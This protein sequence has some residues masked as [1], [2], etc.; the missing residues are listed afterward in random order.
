MEAAPT[1]V[2]ARSSRSSV[3]RRRWG[4]ASTRRVDE[5]G[6]GLATFA[7][8][9]AV[10]LSNLLRRSWRTTGEA[11]LGAMGGFILSWAALVVVATWGPTTIVAG[12]TVT[13]SGT[14]Q[15]GISTVFAILSGLLTGAGER[16]TS[17]TV[18]YGW[19]AVW[20]IVGLAVLRG[21][22]TLPGAV[23]S[24]LLGRLPGLRVVSWAPPHSRV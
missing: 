10:I 18:R 3:R 17:Q 16:R 23:L 5:R 1:V 4:A 24:V 13:A 8:P 14:A 6:E 20:I 12:L 21:A 2:M 11:L 15:V 7:V 9:V 19:T 22:L